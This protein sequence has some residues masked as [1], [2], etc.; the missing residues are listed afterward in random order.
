MSAA[1]DTV[2]GEAHSPDVEDIAALAHVRRLDYQAA[3]PQ[4]WRVADDAVAKHTSYL[5]S[6]VDNPDV[7]ALVAR[8]GPRLQGFVLASLVGPPPVY[9]PGGATGLIDDFAVADERLW[10]TVGRGLLSAARE[11][12]AQLGAAQVVVVCGHHDRAKMSALVASG[13]SR[14]SEWLVAPIASPAA[15]RD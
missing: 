11:R 6:L 10:D 4:F 7:V 15:P 12:L 13:M 2:I 9:R 1:A 14:A 3:Q 8:S 5:A